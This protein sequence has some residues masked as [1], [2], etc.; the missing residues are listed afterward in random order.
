MDGIQSH[1]DFGLFDEWEGKYHDSCFP[2]LMA[3]RIV[4][5]PVKH[6]SVTKDCKMINIFITNNL[7]LVFMGASEDAVQRWWKRFDNFPA[8]I[9]VTYSG[10]TGDIEPIISP[11]LV[12]TTPR[13]N[14]PSTDCIRESSWNLGLKRGTGNAPTN[15]C[16]LS[17]INFMSQ[18]ESIPSL[19]PDDDDE[20][21]PSMDDF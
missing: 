10:C 14:I 9:P 4:Q 17:V 6:G 11:I 2:N 21:E 3:N 18:W 15:T 16:I 7:D 20:H 19:L 12:Y 13:T 5:C 8:P 1:Q